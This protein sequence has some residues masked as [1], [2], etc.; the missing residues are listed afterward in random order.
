MQEFSETAALN[1]RTAQTRKESA[2]ESV[3][4][5]CPV[6]SQKLE[7]RKCKLLCRT[8]GYYMSC[9]DYI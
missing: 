1:P 9:S 8:C 4:S 5:Y 2:P 6:C 7:A 3:S